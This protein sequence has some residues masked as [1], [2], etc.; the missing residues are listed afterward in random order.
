MTAIGAA[1]PDPK[2]VEIVQVFRSGIYGLKGDRITCKLKEEGLHEWA[3]TALV[4]L[5]VR[6]GSTVF[7]VGANIGYYAS[8]FS[9]LVGFSGSVHAFE[10]NPATADLLA[11]TISLN[12]WTN[13]TL[14]RAAVAECSGATSINYVPDLHAPVGEDGHNLGSWSLLSYAAGL[15]TIPLI[16]LDD[17]VAEKRIERLC[18]LKVD[19]EGYEKNVFQGAAFVLRHLRPVMMVEF[20]AS[21]DASHAKC[22]EVAHM[23]EGAGYTLAKVKKKPAPHLVRFQDEMAQQPYHLNVFCLPPKF[24]EMLPI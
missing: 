16:T 2:D 13:T 20:L 5:F 21:D 11:N 10:A 1:R 7:D 24:V 14:V 17:Y 8:L 3:E 12:K 18:F 15:L 4:P 22:Q 23:I 6:Y 9:L 19:V